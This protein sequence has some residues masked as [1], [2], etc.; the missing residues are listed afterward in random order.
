MEALLHPGRASDDD[1]WQPEV[2]LDHDGKRPELHII[3]GEEAAGMA[4]GVD[5]EQ[6]AQIA[7]RLDGLQRLEQVLAEISRDG[8]GGSVALT[9]KNGE[10]SLMSMFGEEAEDS[11]MCGGSHIGVGDTIGECLASAQ[12]A[13]QGT[14]P[15]I[16]W[17]VTP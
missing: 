12:P 4:E 14:L 9:F 15:R 3:V 16:D 1:A 10:W 2:R 7:H 6:Y 13:L 5:A 8:I 17:S 11:P